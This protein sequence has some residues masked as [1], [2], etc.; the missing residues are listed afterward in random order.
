MRGWLNMYRMY[1]HNSKGSGNT[2]VSGK[3][4]V[5]IF[6]YVSKYVRTHV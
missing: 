1:T 4:Q 5:H 3:S 6:M 2:Y